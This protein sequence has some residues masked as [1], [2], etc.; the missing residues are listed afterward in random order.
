[1]ATS[2]PYQTVDTLRSPGVELFSLGFNLAS[3]SAA[4][5]ATYVIPF[6]FKV[7]SITVIPTTI[8]T[9]AAKAAT[10]SVQ[11][12]ST[13]VTGASVALTTANMGALGTNQIGTATAANVGASGSTLNIV[14]SS[15]TAFVEGACTIVVQLINTDAT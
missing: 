13:A 7:A 5:I 11:I 10:V 15:V 4:T 1:M 12:G 2:T 6:N 8:A 3:I 14:G 9:T